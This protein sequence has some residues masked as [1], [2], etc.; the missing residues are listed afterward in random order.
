MGSDGDDLSAQP[1][2][3]VRIEKSF[4]VSKYEITQMEWSTIM[5]FNYSLFKGAKKPVNM[6]SWEDAK[7]YVRLL[8]QKTGENYRLLSEAEWEYAARSGTTTLFNTGSDI[9]QSQANFEHDQLK[10]VGSYPPNAFGLYDMHGNLKEWVEDCF[11]SDYANSSTDGSP[12]L[13]GNCKA[14]VLR[15]GSYPGLKQ[16]IT[17][18]TRHHS[19]ADHEHWTTG[20]RIAKDLSNWPIPCSNRHFC[21]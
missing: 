7:E 3:K 6:L 13:S 20:F 11:N 18:S 8:N 12:I 21:R 2:H 1:K 16:F 17:S 14:R 10:D 15:G 9:T 5:D 19:Y 4:L